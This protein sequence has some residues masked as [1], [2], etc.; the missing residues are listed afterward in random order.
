LAGDYGLKAEIDRIDANTSFL[1][2]ARHRSTGWIAPTRNPGKRVHG[3]IRVL[4]AELDRP[5]Q[6][7]VSAADGSGFETDDESL[8]FHLLFSFQPVIDSPTR[9]V[10]LIQS[11]PDRT[12]ATG[13]DEASVNVEPADREARYE[14]EVWICSRSKGVD[15]EIDS[16]PESLLGRVV[17]SKSQDV[18]DMESKTTFGSSL[19][20]R[21]LTGRVDRIAMAGWRGCLA[22]V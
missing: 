14:F 8:D 3:P 12:F 15:Q 16:V 11:I 1:V 20:S 17:V 9:F 7:L 21:R 18:E 5:Y 19:Q 10:W 2:A 4:D 6:V 13:F 22:T